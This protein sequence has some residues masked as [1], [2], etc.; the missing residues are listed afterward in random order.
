MKL[1]DKII[2]LR[3]QKGWSQEEL[4][5]QMDVSRQSV[6]KWESGASMPDI[7]KIILLSKIFGTTTDYLLKEEESNVV[8]DLKD[9]KDD[10][11]EELG[12]KCEE[13]SRSE[14]DITD[15]EEKEIYISKSEAEEY[16]ETKKQ[17]AKRIAWGVF[18][19]ILSPAPMMFLIA[20]QHTGE[21]NFSEDTAGIL[22]VCI[23]LPIVAIAVAVFIITGLKISKF[24]FVEKELVT[25]DTDVKE[26][27]KTQSEEFAPKFAK[28]IAIGV[29]FCIVAVIPMLLAAINDKEKSKQEEVLVVAM[30]GVLLVFVAIGVYRFVKMG[31]I[32]DSYDQILGQGDYTAE[33]K[34]NNKKNDTF[35]GVYW[36][37]VTAIYLAYS[38]TTMEWHRSWIIWPVAGVLFV[39]ITLILNATINKK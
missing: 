20:L 35:S 24:E 31:I 4:A 33:K 12:M 11:Q 14:E 17:A 25:L 15:R 39:A 19:C 21:Y 7:D 3:K 5:A 36:M 18:L 2:L 27:I 6:S 28:N 26:E 16:L 23:L 32:K 30:V 22:G 37:L 8:Q 34:I 38:F 13:D 9:A 1:A 10:N 29:V